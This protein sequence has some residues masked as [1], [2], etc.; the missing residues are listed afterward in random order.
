MNILCII[1]LLL[2]VQYLGFESQFLA[3][4]IRWCSPVAPA[5]LEGEAGVLLEP[6]SPKATL[7]TASQ[8]CL[9]RGRGSWRN[10]TD[11]KDQVS[12]FKKKIKQK[13]YFRDGFSINQDKLMSLLNKGK[14]DSE[15]QVTGMVGN[16]RRRHFPM[17]V[18]SNTKPNIPVSQNSFRNGSKSCPGS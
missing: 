1:G 14:S 9:K 18:T 6:R 2:V 17:G 4:Q 15:D 5:L 13:S 11:I 10:G 8:S 12:N 7:A 3:G 16:I